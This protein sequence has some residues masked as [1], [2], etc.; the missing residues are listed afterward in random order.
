MSDICCLYSAKELEGL[1]D[2]SK[3]TL[4]KELKKQL[5]A[6]R[7]IRAILQA[8]QRL[9][10]RMGDNGIVI[11]EKRRKRGG[12]LRLAESRHG[13]H[14]LLARAR[15]IRLQ[16]LVSSKGDRSHLNDTMRP[17]PGT[18]ATRWAAIAVITVVSVGQRSAALL[19]KSFMP[20]ASTPA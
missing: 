10:G 15:V 18:R 8:H 2:K 16:A 12:V 13:D 5:Q 4:Q 7:E 17:P 14:R 3:D 6:S 11:P 20:M 9:H 19:T 1:D